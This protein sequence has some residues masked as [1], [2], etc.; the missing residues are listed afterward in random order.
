MLP[1]FCGLVRVPHQRHL[2][3]AV[4]I[5]VNVIS[6]LLD[7]QSSAIKSPDEA[8]AAFENSRDRV[9]SMALVHE[10]LYKSR[11][12]AQM[13]MRNYIEDLGRNILEIHRSGRD[14]RLET[15]VEEGI[16][17]NLNTAVPCGLILTELI[18]NAFKHAFPSG[19]AGTIGVGFRIADDGL[20]ELSVSDDGVGTAK[21]FDP[22]SSLGLTL[23][24]LLSEQIG[25]SLTIS[26]VEGMRCVIKFPREGKS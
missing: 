18:T 21:G 14:I 15:R 3:I 16:M 23:I 5:Q 19:R 6:S 10:E 12:H 4:R 22:G 24:R 17:L 7:L 20:A 25:G 1:K 2:G 9:A 8:L 11:D 26:G 13:D